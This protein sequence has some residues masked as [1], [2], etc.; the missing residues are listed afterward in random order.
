MQ[1]IKNMPYKEEK[2][3]IDTLTKTEN[4]IITTELTASLSQ[5]LDDEQVARYEQLC[6][7]AERIHM[8]PH[9]TPKA[10]MARDFTQWFNSW[11][12]QNEALVQRHE[13]AQACYD[14]LT[15]QPIIMQA[16]A[17][18]IHGEHIQTDLTQANYKKD[19][20]ALVPVEKHMPISCL[21]KLGLDG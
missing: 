17:Y 9:A 16:G 21:Q 3:T 11:L 1:N 12:V 13:K 4:E 10:H 2:H 5:L 20:K 19:A 6:Q 18:D 7:V 14:A 8:T 15:S